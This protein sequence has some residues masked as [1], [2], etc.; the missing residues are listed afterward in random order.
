MASYFRQSRN[1]ELSLLEH[2]KDNF[3]IDW[4]DIELCKTFKQVYA[5]DIDLPIVSVQL[6]E[7]S[8]TRREIGANTLEDRYL[9][10][11]NVFARSDAQRLDIADYIKSKLK[12]GWAHYDWSHP[13]GDNSNLTH[14]PNG[15]DYVTSFESDGRID[16]VETTSSKDKYRHLI[17]IEVRKST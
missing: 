17:T 10:A 15:R 14:T 2:L 6:I 13:S 5:K 9:I 3:A 8:T 16:L 1:C 7:T 11:I 12:D 4:S